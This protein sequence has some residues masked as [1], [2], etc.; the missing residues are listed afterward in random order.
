MKNRLFLFL[1][2][3]LGISNVIV[4]QTKVSGVVYDEN[5]Q[6]LGFANVVFKG[7][8]VG[9]MT[10]IN[11]TF[12]LESSNNYKTVEVSYVG[13]QT[14]AIDVSQSEV[15][16]IKIKLLPEAQLKEVVVFSKPTKHLSKK[17]NP[18]YRILKGI[19]ANKKKNGLA[20]MK[21]Y[22]FKKYTSISL[23]LSNL[24]SVF[25]KKRLGK[26]YDTII[27]IASQDPKLKKFAIPVYM[28]ETNERDY[29]SNLLG[30]FKTTLEAERQTG[31]GQQGFVFDRIGSVFTTIDIYNDDVE[32]LRKSF[33]SPIST[34]GYGIHEYVL[35]D[36]TVVGDKKIYE[37]RFYPRQ[38]QDLAFEGSFKVD[39]KSFA[40]TEIFMRT[41][42][43][44]NLNL[45][46]NLYIE[47]YFETVNDTLYL[48]TR[49]YY[50]ADFTLLTKNDDEKGMFV[51]KN[52]VYDDYDFDIVHDS[53]FYDEVVV[54]TRS[55]QFVKED[56]YWNQVTNLD[57]EL[58]NSRKV[59]NDLKANKKIQRVSN[60][61]NIVSTG[62]I[63]LNK[64]IQFG[65]IWQ[66]ISNNNVEGNRLRAGF[67]SFKTINDLF[68][69]KSYFVYGTLDHKF[70]YGFEA[71]YLINHSPRI[72][73][74]AAVINDNLQLSGNSFNPNDL[75][76]TRSETNVLI[77]R[78]ENLTLT[79]VS[80]NV[81]NIDLAFSDNLHIGVSGVYSHM[82]S[83]DEELF[84]IDYKLPNE[85][86][87][88]SVVRDFANSISLEWTPKRRVNGF[89]VEQS[90]GKNLFSSVT[91]KYTHGYKG[92][93]GSDFNY[94]K[95]QMAFK[96]PLM[97]SNF[98]VLGMYLEG[99]KTFG[100]VPLTLLSPINANQTYSIV[101]NSF[102]MIDY[103]DMMT[104]TY[105]TAH[106]EH[107][108]NGFILNKIPLIN[109][110]KYRSVLF[111][112]S[113]YG[114]ISKD[115]VAINQS[116]IVYKAPTEK[117]Y[118]EYGFGIENIGF[119]NFRPI[120]IDFI[121]RAT[122]ENVNG[123]ESPKFGVRFG[124]IPDF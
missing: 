69:A 68:R 34:R 60:V 86:E 110:L 19:W 107:H 17:E 81:L 15:V 35:G 3:L 40:I 95:V 56:S 24:D 106:F 109:K 20:L 73:I 85:T 23:G 113:I 6:P 61:I 92:I 103:Y 112:K 11:G 54:Q 124:F 44:I 62:Y 26:D 42:R 98:G 111:Y 36:S 52:I 74:G 79:K 82:K 100:T 50:E 32:I 115:N 119:G 63:P 88:K 70:K 96:K 123:P 10:D 33:V 97:I 5:N 51:K 4:A 45:V 30:K 116:S 21:Q 55:N 41:N 121:W 18:A 80:K 75:F 9:V 37:I 93:A 48:P 104:D 83:A 114:T 29:G 94:N 47:K 8:N 101:S 38:D 102:S 31:L 46:R 1:F 72:V 77:A 49:D 90:L 122:F 39:S 118:S 57:K 12:L 7:S 87:A 22:E 25:L 76:P 43:K 71:K 66:S 65:S 14:S 120:R 53:S 78:G 91:L 27:A 28:K 99:G 16:N 58:Q 89:G 2:F 108:F 13:F 105:L 84:S 117:L 64:Y 67:R 59:I